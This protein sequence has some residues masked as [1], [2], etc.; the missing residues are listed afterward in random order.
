M[1]APAAATNSSN[2]VRDDK[3]ARSPR[4][5]NERRARELSAR[6]QAYAR[7]DRCIYCGGDTPGTTVDHCPPRNFFEERR[8]PEGYV[9]PACERCN[10]ASRHEEEVC[11]LVARM[12]PTKIPDEAQLMRWGKWLSSVAK[13][14]RPLVE[15]MFGLTALE[16]KAQAERIGLKRA[17]GELYRDL[18]IVSVP[19]GVHKAIGVISVKLAKA[20]HYFHSTRIVPAGAAIRH[21]WFSNVNA[22]EGTMPDLSSLPMA[23]AA[24]A[25]AAVDLSPQFKYHWRCDPNGEVGVYVVTVRFA[26][27]IVIFVTFDPANMPDSGPARAGWAPYG[28]GSA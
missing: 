22:L 13:K 14:D 6:Q 1:S 5:T 23:E 4:P 3:A 17:P 9:F 12:D 20:L 11:A 2:S 19:D 10:F 24:V 25:R 8:W 7:T 26:F 28:H 21:A 16:K 15:E 27:V 18:P